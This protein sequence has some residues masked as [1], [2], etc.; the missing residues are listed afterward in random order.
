MLMGEFGFAQIILGFLEIDYRNNAEIIG[1][2]GTT[3]FSFRRYE[4]YVGK[5]GGLTLLQCLLP[6]L[7]ALPFKFYLALCQRG[8]GLSQEALQL[9]AVNTGEYLARDNLLARDRK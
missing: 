2:I 8:F 4:C 7:D 5:I 3:L 9:R 6:G 1:F